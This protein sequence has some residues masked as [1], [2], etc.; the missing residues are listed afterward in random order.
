MN[1]QLL[2]DRE[3]IS[4]IIDVA[5]AN[6]ARLMQRELSTYNSAKVG[7]AVRWGGLTALV[8]FGL[9]FISTREVNANHAG[10]T[11]SSHRTF[12]RYY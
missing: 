7:E 1:T 5:K 10:F 12:S 9:A 8:A 6:R 3:S 2:I 4:Q 11:T